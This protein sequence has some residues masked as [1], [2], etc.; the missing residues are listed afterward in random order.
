MSPFAY[1]PY[2]L[3]QH[4]KGLLR[5]QKGVFAFSLKKQTT[6]KTCNLRTQKGVF[7][8]RVHS[9]QPRKRRLLQT[10]EWG[11]GSILQCHG[12]VWVTDHFDNFDEVNLKTSRVVN[13]TIKWCT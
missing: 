13:H 9:V 7:A 3:A 4:T 5:T 10:Q 1:R 12:T 8:S 2:F 11:K 6:R